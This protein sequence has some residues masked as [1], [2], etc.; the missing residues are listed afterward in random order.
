MK[1]DIQSLQD[2]FESWYSINQTSREEVNL[3]MDMYHNRQWSREQVWE[4]EGRGQPKE[5]FNIIKSL[6]RTLVGYYSTVV[7]KAQ[8]EPTTYNDITKATMLNDIMKKEYDRTDFDIVDDDIKT[9]G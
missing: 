7:N 8:V 2:Y 3:V 9:Y 4:L 5:T 1:T 6:T